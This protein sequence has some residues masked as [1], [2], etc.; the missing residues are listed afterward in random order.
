[1]TYITY[2]PQRLTLRPL[3]C[4]LGFHAWRAH[5]VSRVAGPS[6][7]YCILCGAEQQVSA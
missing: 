7:R 3:R 4:V 5:P 1:M 6:W 2:R